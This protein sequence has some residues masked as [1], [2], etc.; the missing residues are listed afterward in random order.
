MDCLELSD[1][2]VIQSTV[3]GVLKELTDELKAKFNPNFKVVSTDSGFA[4]V[5]TA[6]TN[7]VTLVM[8]QVW[9][10]GWMTRHQN[11]SL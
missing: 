11:Q 1:S 9:A 3:L 4:V 7:T 2:V 5:T 6:P 8:C 10:D